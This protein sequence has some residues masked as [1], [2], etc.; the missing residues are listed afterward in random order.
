MALKEC[1]PVDH[2][3]GLLR[4]ACRSGEETDGDFGRRQHRCNQGSDSAKLAEPSPAG[5]SR[6]NINNL[7]S[8]R[9]RHSVLIHPMAP[10]CKALSDFG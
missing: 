4:Q 7:L 5:L 1:E 6:L 10:E 8:F 2:G 9:L 3:Y